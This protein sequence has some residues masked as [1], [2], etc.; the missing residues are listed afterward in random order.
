[1]VKP[2]AGIPRIL[3]GGVLLAVTYN[4]WAKA[5]SLADRAAGQVHY[6]FMG[7]PTSPG[8]FFAVIGAGALLG[9]WLVV[10]G[11]LGLAKR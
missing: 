11:L 10:S 9:L 5:G 4:I 3:L 2:M 6:H 1:M 8:V 7:E